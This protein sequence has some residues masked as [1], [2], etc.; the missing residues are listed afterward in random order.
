[1]CIKIEKKQHIERKVK[2]H[3]S[4]YIYIYKYNICQNGHKTSI[5]DIMYQKWREKKKIQV[6]L[7]T[8]LKMH[9]PPN[10]NLLC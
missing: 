6:I 3:T 4:I 2:E 5:Q 9:Y 8:S 1:M 10:K 7:T